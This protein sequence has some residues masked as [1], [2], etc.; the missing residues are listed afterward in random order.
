[1]FIPDPNFSITDP[2]TKR[3]RI[4]TPD[5]YPRILSIFNLFLSFRKNNLGYSSRIPNPYFFHPEFWMRIPD[6]VVKKAPDPGY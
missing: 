4:P 1:M 2:G 5:P 3:F 6:P